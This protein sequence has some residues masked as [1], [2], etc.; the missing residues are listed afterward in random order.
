MKQALAALQGAIEVLIAGSA[1]G[2]AALLQE[3]AGA[4]AGNA[5]RRALEVIPAKAAISDKQMA[6]LSAFTEGKSGAHYAPQS[7]TIQGILKDLY[8]T[9]STNVEQST[10]KEAV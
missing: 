3:R 6:L 1:P 7:L 4:A 5:V 10:S 8:N 9:F 2:A